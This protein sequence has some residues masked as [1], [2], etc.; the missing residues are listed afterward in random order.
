M[1]AGVVVVP[2]DGGECEESLPDAHEDAGDGAA[3]VSFEVE[4]AFEGVV[5]RFDD[6]A[7][8]FEE[9]G[10]GSVGFALAG[11]AQQ[12]DAE[13]G[14][15]GFEL[16]AVVVLVRDQRLPDPSGQVRIA[17]EDV[18]QGVAFVG[19]GAGERETDRQPVQGA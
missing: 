19:L 14:Q 18:E 8:W 1:L 17:G 2:D 4:L 12:L 16:A 15:G 6:L 11:R 5:D 13:L 3:A 10:A 7:Q 9:A